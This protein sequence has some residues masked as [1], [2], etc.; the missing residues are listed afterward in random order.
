MCMEMCT[1]YS[2]VCMT[3]DLYAVCVSFCV[4]MYACTHKDMNVGELREVFMKRL[5]D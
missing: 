5:S 2:H 4:S 3:L 1:L